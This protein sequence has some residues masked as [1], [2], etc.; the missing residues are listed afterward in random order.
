MMRRPKVSAFADVRAQAP[1]VSAA[2]GRWLG[3]ILMMTGM[4]LPFALDFVTIVVVSKGA[5]H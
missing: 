3:F 1:A 2:F 4:L 5:S